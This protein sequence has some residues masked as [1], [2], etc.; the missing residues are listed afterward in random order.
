VRVERRVSCRGAIT[1]AGQRIQ[2]G[3]HLAGSILCVE[4]ADTTWR[5][6]DGTCLV[7]EVAR[8]TT[9]NIAR[10]KVRKP[11]PPRRIV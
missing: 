3:I 5:L 8:T 10:F 7:V 4:A 9:K 1:V 11:E 6:Y 2:A